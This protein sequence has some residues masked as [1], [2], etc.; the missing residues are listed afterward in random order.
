MNEPQTLMMT[1]DP[2]GVAGAAQRVV[3]T[4]SQVVGICLRALETDDL[5]LPE[6]RGGPIGYRFGGP[7]ISNEEKRET[8]KN[9]V[10]GKGFQD[11]ARG[12]RETLEEAFFY[13]T[14][15]KREPG[16][17]TWE[18]VQE[19]MAQIRKKAS[20]LTFPPLLDKV[21]AS[22]IEP[23]AFDAEFRTLQKVRNCL[24]HRGGR[25]SDKDVDAATGAMTLSFPRLKMFYY[26]GEEEIEVAPGE[27]I[28]THS[29]DNP[30]GKGKDVQILIRRATRYRTY[31]INEPVVITTSDFYEIA[32][33][34]HLFAGDVAAKLPTAP[35]SPLP[36]TTP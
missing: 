17:T 20:D 11:L 10:L 18:Q 34:C 24:E 21:N 15:L 8:Y 5:S 36:S 1:L 2:N 13:V 6:M 28:D 35:L 4:A 26:R 14:M 25:V 12:I 3:Q 30:F 7:P 33:A 27:V 32:M 29:P 19:D 22:L 31:A 9:W 23:M 16:L